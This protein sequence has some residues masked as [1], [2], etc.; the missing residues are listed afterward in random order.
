MNSNGKMD[1]KAL[2][3]PEPGTSE[4]YVAPGNEIEKQ[5][6][7]IWSE[8]LGTDEGVIGIDTNFFE[9][10]G[11][12]L[13]AMKLI[14]LLREKFNVKISLETFFQ[15]GTIKQIAGLIQESLHD[16]E[17]KTAEVDVSA[18]DLKFIKKKRREINI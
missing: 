2:P 12:S 8:I 7:K 1:I 9:L 15:M 14:S 6:V 10:G 11:Q 16:P 4:E 3:E 18:S 5:L 17:K 13:M